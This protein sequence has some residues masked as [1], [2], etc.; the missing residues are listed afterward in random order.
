MGVTVEQYFK[1][2]YGAL[3]EPNKT[4]SQ[5]K[6]SPCSSRAVITIVWVNILL[7]SLKYAFTANFL[8]GVMFVFGLIAYIVSVLFG[9]L[10]LGVFFEYIA[11]IFDKSGQLKKL[12]YLTSYAI[13][14]WIFIAPLELLKNSSAMGYFFGVL[15]E[16]IIYFWT[17]FL[18]CKSLQIAYNLKV[19][20][21]IML[22]FLPFVAM[23]FAFFWTIGFITKL[24]Y[25]FTV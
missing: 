19:S 17:I 6:E 1:N 12:L 24:G 4:F 14:P 15:L 25:I 23:V 9:W 2:V 5:L 20:R 8:N 3:F 10:M 11:K 22:I 21:A 18:Y 7:Y 16:I 13:L